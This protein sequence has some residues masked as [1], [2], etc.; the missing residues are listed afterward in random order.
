MK[1]KQRPLISFT[2]QGE[3]TSGH[4]KQHFSTLNNSLIGYPNGALGL[5][6]FKLKKKNT[7]T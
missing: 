2:A 3:V 5:C 7:E 1:S 6:S 4:P